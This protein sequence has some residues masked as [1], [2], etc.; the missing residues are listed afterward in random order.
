TTVIVATVILPHQ[1]DGFLE[2]SLYLRVYFADGCPDNFSFI[3][4]L[5]AKYHRWIVCSMGIRSR[6]KIAK[7]QVYIGAEKIILTQYMIISQGF[8]FSSGANICI[9]DVE[10]RI[11]AIP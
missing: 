9:H 4:L 8:S 2:I 10:D 6:V 7:I 3:R 11:R 5:G 1:L